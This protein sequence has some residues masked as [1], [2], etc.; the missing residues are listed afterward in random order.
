[1]EFNFKNYIEYCKV[2]NIKASYYSSLQMFT[3][4]IKK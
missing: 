4:E 3:K 2:N 1:M